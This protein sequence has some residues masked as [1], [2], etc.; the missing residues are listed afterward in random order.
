MGGRSLPGWIIGVTGVGLVLVLGAALLFAGPSPPVPQ[1]IAFNHLKHTQDLGLSCSFC[2]QYVQTGA[3]AGLPDEQI[4]RMC[5]LSP[6]GTSDEAA[7]VT[8]LLAAGQPLRFNKL[9]RLAPHVLYTHRRHVGIAGLECTNCH[10]GIADTERPPKRALVEID[11]N[12]CLDCHLE[13][14]QSVDCVACHR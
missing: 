1:P 13:Q 7:K 6:Q 5:H 4:C 3:H 14:G 12:F 2:H 10:G 9:F 8:E 11:M